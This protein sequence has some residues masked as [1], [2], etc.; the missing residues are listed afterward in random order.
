MRRFSRGG[1]ALPVSRRP[2]GSNKGGYRPTFTT[3]VAL[4]AAASLL[5][6]VLLYYRCGAP[7]TLPAQEPVGVIAARWRRTRSSQCRVHAA[8]G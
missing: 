5:S 3:L 1:G 6:T 2:G 8:K 4:V 7:A